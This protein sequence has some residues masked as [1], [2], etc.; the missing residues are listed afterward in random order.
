MMTNLTLVKG[1]EVAA[2][3]PLPF[4]AKAPSFKM[5]E[6]ATGQTWTTDQLFTRDVFAVYFICNHCPHSQAWE[7]RLLD[8]AYSYEQAT[9]HRRPPAL[10]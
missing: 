2:E 10:R 7:P 6:P 8:L 5:L 9:H 1:H 4:G 3:H